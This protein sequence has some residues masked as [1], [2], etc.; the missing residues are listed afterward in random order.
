MLQNNET[1]RGGS[2]IERKCPVC[3]SAE[4]RLLFHDRNRREGYP[5][6]TSYVSCQICGMRYLNPVP[7]PDEWLRHYSDL[8][9]CKEP[10]QNNTWV[11]FI[12]KAISGWQTLWSL[13]MNLH[14]APYEL[15]KQ[16]RLLD[17]G[18]GSGQKLRKYEKCEGDIYGI[19]VSSEAV[20]KARAASKGNYLIGKFED[21][22]YPSSYFDV[23]RFDN[24]LEHVYEPRVFLGKVYQLLRPG[25]TAYGYVPNGISP[26]MRLMGRYSISSWMP[27]HL[28]LFVP[29]ALK[30]LAQDVG[31]TA[32]V[33]S[34]S[35]PGWVVLS[36]LQ[37]L[38]RKQPHFDIKTTSWASRG[39]AVVT[40][41][42]WWLL[43]RIWQGEELALIASKPINAIRDCSSPR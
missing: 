7:S 24:V 16:Q 41:P 40:A 10:L 37:W 28:N 3:S 21:A 8:Y 29:S 23:I 13:E 15:P 43:S 27:F 20:G 30:T 38:N 11:E 25:G 31:F 34:L 4:R 42:L 19:D 39:T 22:D 9:Q 26:T 33:V 35:N 6:E 5:V 32:K 18:C 36:V 12:D 17:I 14:Q 2:W 1:F